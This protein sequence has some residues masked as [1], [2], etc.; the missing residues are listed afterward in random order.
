MKDINQ[1]MRT[2]KQLQI[3]YQ[4]AIKSKNYQLW[5]TSEVISWIINLDEDRYTKY[6]KELITSMNNERF[7][8]TCLDEL[9]IDDLHRLGIT[10]FKDK[11]EIFNAIQQLRN[12]ND[13]QVKGKENMTNFE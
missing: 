9:E 1:L 11:K 3:Q 8:G 7:D 12:F 10:G 5:S 13:E 4:Q 6:K 2:N